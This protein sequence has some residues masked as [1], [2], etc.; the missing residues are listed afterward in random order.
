[1]RPGRMG[2]RRGLL[3]LSQHQSLVRL[4]PRPLRRGLGHGGPRRMQRC[5]RLCCGLAPPS[6]GAAA[7]LATGRDG[8]PGP[9]GRCCQQSQSLY[10]CEL[11]DF[12]VFLGRPPTDLQ[13]ALASI[14]LFHI[15]ARVVAYI[16]VQ[17]ENYACFDWVTI[18]SYMIEV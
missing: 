1:M 4:R 3:V 15:I 5:A 18:A 17:N 10:S 6:H 9:L 14:C 11:A 2:R 13:R 8:L 16:Q 12:A 7:T